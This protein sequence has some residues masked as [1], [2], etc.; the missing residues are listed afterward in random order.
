MTIKGKKAS[1][2]KSR[3]SF[4]RL[5][6]PHKCGSLSVALFLPNTFSLLVF[7]PFLK[8]SWCEKKHLTPHDPHIHGQR[9]RLQTSRQPSNDSRPLWVKLANNPSNGPS[10]SRLLTEQSQRSRRSFLIMHL[11]FCILWLRGCDDEKFYCR[12][13]SWEVFAHLL[14]YKKGFSQLTTAGCYSG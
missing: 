7:L 1:L 2:A 8:I 14:L 3:N 11:T 4:C 13:Y 5:F 9:W 6:R 12:H 10:D